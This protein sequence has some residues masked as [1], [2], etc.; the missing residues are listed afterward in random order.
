MSQ[1]SSPKDT[2]L[3]LAYGE[4]VACEVLSNRGGNGAERGHEPVREG[5]RQL[6]ACDRKPIGIEIK[7]VKSGWPIGMPTCRPRRDGLYAVRS[8][9]SNG[10][11]ARILFCIDA[12]N[13]IGLHGFMKKTQQIPAQ[14]LDL[15]FP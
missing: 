8:E 7:T 11:I 14:D 2:G 13:L 12:G 15:A 4:T 1:I 5:L 10:K 3:A 9:L 6:E